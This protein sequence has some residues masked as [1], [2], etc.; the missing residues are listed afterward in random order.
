MSWRGHYYGRDHE[1]TC[2]LKQNEYDTIRAQRDRDWSGTTCNDATLSDIDNRAITKAREGF[3]ARNPAIGAE[4]DAWSDATFLSKAKLTRGGKLTYA[5][6]LLLGKAESAHF[7]SPVDATIFWVRKR[8]DG[9]NA[10]FYPFTPPYVVSVDELFTRVKNDRY[11]FMREG[12][13]FPVDILQYDAWV[14]REMLHNAIAHQDYRQNRRINVIERDATL[15]FSNAGTFEPGSVEVVVERNEPQDHFR[16]LCLVEAMRSINMIETLG[17]GIPRVYRL[18]KQRGFP[19]T[20]YDLSDPRTVSV[21]V[22]GR[23]LDENYT[24]ALL[25]RPDIEIRDVIALDKVQKGVRLDAS[26]FSRLR[27]QGLVEGTRTSA[28]VAAHMVGSSEDTDI[29]NQIILYLREGVGKSALIM[30]ALGPHLAASLSDAQKANKVRNAVQNL[31]RKGRVKN[32]GKGGRGAIWEL[33]E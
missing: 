1:A 29:E 13:L 5:A 4:C 15:Q 8:D 6:L 20:D 22:Y 3:K 33:L 9:T 32:R 19:M 16:N 11:Q 24:R 31:A 12:T 2:P 14:I 26:T 10:D 25:A 30:A 28:K 18:Q 17:S 23:V 27:N 7:L 21:K